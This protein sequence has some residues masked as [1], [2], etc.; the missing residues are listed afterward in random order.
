MKTIKKLTTKV[1]YISI[2]VLSLI[3]VD[4][5]NGQ[6]IFSEGREDPGCPIMFSA[7]PDVSRVRPRRG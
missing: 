3:T 1:Y 2:I 5:A 4:V 6:N 7:G